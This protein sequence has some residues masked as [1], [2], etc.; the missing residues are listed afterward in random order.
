MST[1][2]ALVPT[3]GGDVNCEDTRA[4]CRIG[5]HPRLEFDV[6]A[7]LDDA[8]RGPQAGPLARHVWRALGLVRSRFGRSPYAGLGAVALSDAPRT[9]R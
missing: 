1:D 2:A 6:P 4:P 5:G 9:R 8:C 7:G 3:N